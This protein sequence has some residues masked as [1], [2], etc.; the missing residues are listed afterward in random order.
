MWRSS[1]KV[2]HAPVALKYFED[3]IGLKMSVIRNC[4][5]YYYGHLNDSVAEGPDARGRAVSGGEPGRVAI[6]DACIAHGALW[7]DPSRHIRKGGMANMSEM[8]LRPHGR[9]SHQG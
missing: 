8:G 1:I 3:R 2:V 9:A 7:H 5:D 6:Q 4:P